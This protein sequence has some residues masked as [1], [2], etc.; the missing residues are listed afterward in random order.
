M[1]RFKGFDTLYKKASTGKIVEWRIAVD[2]RSDV[3]TVVTR[4][5]EQGGKIQETSDAVRVGKNIGKANETTAWEQAVKEAHSKWEKQLKK[6]YV[7][8]LEYIEADKV[9]ELIEG[10]IAPMLAHKY[11]EHGHKI[12]WPALV[13]PKLD[14]HRCI[15]VVKEGSC[16]LWSRTRKRIKSM[17]HIERAVLKLANELTL[18]N[19]ILDGELYTHEGSQAFQR[20]TSLIRADEPRPGHEQIEYWLYDLPHLAKDGKTEEERQLALDAFSNIG[21]LRRVQTL[22][23]QDEEDMLEQFDAFRANGFEGL[24]VR[25]LTGLYVNKRSYDLQKVKEFDDGEFP[26]VDLEEGR[27]KLAG[28]AIF[29]CETKS[30]GRFS[31][32]LKGDQEQLRTYWQK[33]ELV[34]GKQVTVRY[35]GLTDDGLPRFGVGLRLREDI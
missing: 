18:G 19:A 3:A 12:K 14:G 15:A 34:I 29:V 27:G 24:M 20:L 8:S 32:K 9:D 23:A 13:Q 33:P 5:G 7:R 6:G 4:W 31:V 28:H 21:P 17:P 35:Q 11:S 30:G 26:I 2:E 16:S 25:N 10:G 22:L 1:S